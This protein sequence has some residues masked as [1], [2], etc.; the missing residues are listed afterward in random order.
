MA[1]MKE[2]VRMTASCV[3]HKLRTKIKSLIVAAKVFVKNA[4]YIL[5]IMFVV[6]AGNL[7]FRLGYFQEHEA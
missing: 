3:L 4:K 2:N 1:C 5:K 6:S 7:N